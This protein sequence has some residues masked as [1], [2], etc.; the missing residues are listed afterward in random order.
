MS[1]V[2]V[3]RERV[4]TVAIEVFPAGSVAV[5]FIIFDPIESAGEIVHSQSQLASTIE[6]HVSHDGH[7]AIIVSHVTPV[8]VNI[9]VV[10]LILDPFVGLVITGT[11]GAV[12]S[13]ISP[14]VSVVFVFPVESVT[15]TISSE[16]EICHPHEPTVHIHSTVHVPVAGLGLQLIFGIVRVA[17]ISTPIQV[18]VTLVPSFAIAG[19]VVQV[20]AIGEVQ[21]G[22]Q[23]V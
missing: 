14:V 12:V 7:V 22:V 10:S 3:T 18:V 1:V 23:S 4:V 11:S 15:V 19:E 21:S 6:V 13:I 9:G 8:P 2:S 20:D 16:V 17:H 5:I